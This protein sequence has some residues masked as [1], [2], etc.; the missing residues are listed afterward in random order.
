M[1]NR[2]GFTLIE[3]LAT[4]AI[5]SIVL[6]LGTFIVLNVIVNSKK[7]AFEVSKK[8]VFESANL[9]A[10]E[11][12]DDTDWVS[13]EDDSNTEKS[14]ISVQ[15]LIN[16]GYV[17][18]EDFNSGEENDEYKLNISDIV[19]LNKDA[20]TKNIT[21]DN[22]YSI[23]EV[24]KDSCI[25]LLNAE[26]ISSTSTTHSI[27][28]NAECKIKDK[29]PGDIK[30][31]YIIG[32]KSS[33]LIESNTYTRDKLNH[34]TKYNISFRCKSEEFG[35]SAIEPIEIDTKMLPTPSIKVNSTTAVITFGKTDSS[36]TKK[37]SV[38]GTGVKNKIRSLEYLTK[39]KEYDSQSSLITLYAS[40]IKN[41][42]TVTATNSD[43]YNILSSTAIIIKTEETNVNP[44][45]FYPSDEIG[46]GNWHNSDFT[47]SLDSDNNGTVTYYYG[48]NENNLN[49]NYNSP[50]PISNE[51]VSTTYYAK[52]CIGNICSD[53]TSYEVKLD[54]TGPELNVSARDTNNNLINVSCSSD[55]CSNSDWI[56]V[57]LA[58]DINASDTLSGL[59]SKEVIFRYSPAGQT[60]LG[61]LTGSS[62]ISLDSNNKG[63]RTI[64]SD[65]YRH[66]QFE[67]CDQTGNCTTKNMKLMVDNTAPSV[68]VSMGYTGSS[69]SSISLSIDGDSYSNDT[70]HNKYV[71]LYF[72]AND[73]LSGLNNDA[74]FSYNY[75]YNSEFN[76]SIMGTDNVDLSS[77]TFTRSI[78]SDGN[79][80]VTFNVCDNTNNCVT[81]KIKFK[82][83]T[84]VPYI[85]IDNNN[86]K[87]TI[88]CNPSFSG[89]KIFNLYDNIA[90]IRY[91]ADDENATSNSF[92]Y[93]PSTSNVNLRITC[94]N[95]AENYINKDYI[96]SS[97]T[98][99]PADDFCDV[100]ESATCCLNYCKGLNKSDR[101]GMP[102]K[103]IFNFNKCYCCDSLVTDI[104]Y[105]NG[106][107]LAI[108]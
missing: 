70:W 25:N 17:K 55:T 50:I 53:V 81:K 72:T 80:Y 62:T 52:A 40:D 54:K 102:W 68:G 5:I 23:S 9:Y 85:Y 12:L 37:Y 106:Y 74:K 71:T 34:N 103:G 75:G 61:N 64:S 20:I 101:T 48:T 73:S 97:T 99:P 100:T 105:S 3:L 26:L 6:S 8:S 84:I 11:F 57:N 51:T 46:S 67:I 31:E 65:G 88:N 77:G 36:I 60:Y 78:T 92:I 2:K 30:Y 96:Y 59:S 28:V 22:I 108:G 4:I 42:V 33:G 21:F 7:K 1:N 104:N 27:T 83:D 95:N 69:G 47:L 18:E 93:N 16:K 45:S 14:C 49:L 86:N 39:D 58:F 13:S 66:Y 87:L 35:E 24:D 76:D 107:C 90:N 19:I 89:V 41:N 43:G 79:R 56:S 82:I 10:N 38:D 32:D 44:P 63:S 98:S 29:I 94:R 15:W 91:P